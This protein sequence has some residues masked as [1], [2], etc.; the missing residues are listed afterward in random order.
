MCPLSVSRGGRRPETAAALLALAGCGRDAPPP[1][2][3]AALPAT[4]AEPVVDDGGSAP[5][6]RIETAADA[7][8]AEAGARKEEAEADAG[9]TP[10]GMVTLPAGIFLMG[11]P[12]ERGSPE[13]RPMHEVVVAAFD[14]DRT[15]IRTRDYLAC[16]GAGA[17]SRPHEDNPFCNTS[18]DAQ[19]DR[20]DHPINCIDAHQAEAYC[21]FAGKRLPTEREWEYAAR[22]GAEERR[23]SW[24][25]EDPSSERACY[26]HIG[27]SVRWDP[28]RLAPSGLADM[29]HGKTSGSGPRAGSAPTPT[30]RRPAR[31]A[32][33][34]AGAG[35]AASPSGSPPP[36]ATATSPITGAPRSAPAAPGPASPSSAPPR[37]SPAATPASACAAPPAASPPSPGTATPARSAAAPRP[38]GPSAAWTLRPVAAVP[39]EQPITR[40]RTPEHDGDCQAHYAGKPAAYRYSGGDSSHSQ[41]AAPGGR[42]LPAAGHGAD[43]GRAS[44]C[45]Q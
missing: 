28:S 31:T 15:E 37:P 12:V 24:G 25:E 17:C 40:A 39:E 19:G 29:R 43:L 26:D 44:R 8:A 35:A 42:G 6:P 18:K 7:G 21:A 9:L 30:R 11:S 4:T 13:E 10:A 14:L 3:P 22:G 36:C 34:A 16:M 38:S 20:S 2:V 41:P 1:P 23:Y 33:T 32:S 45:P 27:T 5:K